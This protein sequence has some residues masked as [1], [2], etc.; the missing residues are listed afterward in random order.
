M[1]RLCLT[2][3]LGILWVLPSWADGHTPV[4]RALEAVRLKEWDTAAA[5]VRRAGPVAQDIV[6]W[7]RLRAGEG[8]AQQVLTFLARRPAWPGLQYLR[9][10]SESAFGHASRRQVDAFFSDQS[11]QTADG[12]FLQASLLQR[13]GDEKTAQEKAVLAWRTMSMSAATQQ[14]FLERYRRILAPHHTARLDFVLWKGWKANTSQMLPLVSDGW[15]ALARARLGLRNMGKN[16]DGLIGAVPAKLQ[17]DPGLAY[18]RFQWRARKGRN[19]SAIELVLAQSRAKALGNPAK[20]AGWRRSLARSEMRSENHKTAYL[21]AADH[22]LSEGSSYSDLEWLSGYLA[23]RFLN[24]PDVALAHFA[25]FKASV[26]TPIS[27][28]RAEYWIGRAYDAKGDHEAGRRA[29]RLGGAHQTSFYGLLAAEKAGMPVDPSLAG[30]EQFPD[31]RSAA[32]TKSSVH[33]AALLLLKA[34]DVSLAERFW[35]HLAETQERTSLGQMGQMAQD[36]KSPHIAVML[37]KRMVRQGVTLPGPYYPLH[38]LRKSRLP[39]PPEMALAIAR[40]ES[41]FDSVVVSGAG[42]RG[43]MQL[44][45]NTARQVAGALNLNYKKSRLTSDPVYNATLGS[46]YLAGL[47]RDFKGNV[48]MIAAGYNAGPS[49]PTRWMKDRGDPRSGGMDIIDWIEHIPFN[50]TRNYVMR[51]AE[52]LPVYRARLGKKPLPIPFSHELVGSSILLLSP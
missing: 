39:I 9:K 50:E 21:I 2:V 51:V 26:V 52:S 34:G 13:A 47:A 18:E 22:G 16:V 42:A 1:L 8:S 28:G 23:L 12:I 7:H 37:G 31:W 41:E 33:K 36:L 29:Y 6:E 40:R 35:V 20:W 48:I 44:M 46:A 24:K 3:F 45:P 4:T 17:N 30:A 10:K 27:L 25:R 32:F 38:D 49:R 11:A 15:A 43:L 14:K 19:A 5:H